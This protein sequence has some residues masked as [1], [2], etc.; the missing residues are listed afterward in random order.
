MFVIDTQD[1]DCLVG[2]FLEQV[3]MTI[4]QCGRKQLPATVMLFSHP[5][6]YN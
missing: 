6:Q 3:L 5:I 1:I 4:R 2:K